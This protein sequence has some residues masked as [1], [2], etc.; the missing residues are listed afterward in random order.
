[1]KGI[2]LFLAY[3]SFNDFVVYQMDVKSAFLYE[4]I[5]EEV[6][7]CQPPRFEDPDFLDKVYKVEKALYGLHQAPRA[8]YETLSTYLLENGFHS[9]KIDK[10]LFIRRYKDD[11]LLVQVYVDYIIFGELTFFLGL[12]VKQKQDGIF[13]S[14]DKYV[15]EILK[16]YGFLEVKN[17]STPMKTQKSLLKDEDGKEVDV[18]MYRSMIGSL[19]YL[20]SLRPDIMFAV[21]AYCK[22]QTVVANSTTQAEY[23][24]ASSCRRQFWA[25][26]KAKTVNREGQL[27]ALVDGKKVII[28]KSTIRRDLQL[29]DAEGVDCL[30]NAI[31]F[32]QLTLMRKPR[33]KVTEVPQPSNPTSVVDEAV[34]EE[35][36]DSLERAATTATSLDAE[37]DKGGGP[38]CQETIKDTIAQT[39]VL[40]LETIKTTQAMEIKS[41]KRR[42]KKLERRKRS[43]THGLKRLYK[44]G[45][46]ARV[47]SSDDEGLGEED[48]SKQGRIDDIDANEGIT[49]LDEEVALK[50]Q[51]KLQVEFEKE[52]RLESERAQQEVEANIA[53]IESWDDVQAKIDADYQR[54]E[55]L[56]AEEQQELNDE[57][58]AKLF[59]E[60]ESAKKKKIDDDKDTAERE[61]KAT[62]RYMADGSLKIYLIFSH[63]L[64]DFDKE[65]V[66]TL[67]KLVKA[68][69]GSTR[70][71][72]DYERVLWDDL[73]V[74]FDPHVEDEV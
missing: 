62:I 3:A 58:K 56:Q 20:T 11:I 54:A 74:M 6:Y 60:Q 2:R 10:T 41:L 4:K 73:K 69:Y 38:R 14:H 39:R 52:Q 21:Y 8:W 15:A 32:E 17:A 61:R 43:R 45:L 22:K 30:P 51:A 44:V 48:A 42:V 71:E 35:I 16:K 47:K 24:A 5:K 46:S 37:Q 9:G 55:R 23:V 67:W 12:Q 27:K 13:I 28:T 40:D 26:I 50:L 57:E 34:N 65:D 70:P 68:M 31:I 1:M 53:L 72:G 59:P 49:F 66:E 19:M 25:T 63:M 36:D 18:H 29:E 7:V 64:K 33:R